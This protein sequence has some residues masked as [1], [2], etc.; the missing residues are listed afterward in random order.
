MVS[1]QRSGMFD[2]LKVCLINRQQS[3]FGLIVRIFIRVLLLFVAY[4]PLLRGFKGWWAVP[5][6]Q[7][8]QSTEIGFAE[9]HLI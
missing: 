2:C 8:S 9:L 1:F 5:T 4:L 7:L 3:H 6:L